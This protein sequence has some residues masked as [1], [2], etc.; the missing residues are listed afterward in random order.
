MNGNS[1]ALNGLR[2]SSRP[3]RYHL[4][5]VSNLTPPACTTVI[6]IIPAALAVTGMLM[7]WNRVLS[8]RR[9]KAV[10]PTADLAPRVAEPAASD[11]PSVFA[12]GPSIR[13]YSLFRTDCWD[14]RGGSTIMQFTP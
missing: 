14:K 12:G 1:L 7:Y 5:L 10:T 6:G 3:E 2:S 11:C 8:K 4:A 13:R 9:R